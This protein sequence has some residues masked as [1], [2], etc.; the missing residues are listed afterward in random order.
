VLLDS[1]PILAVAD[2]AILAPLVDGVLVVAARDHT[3]GKQFDLAL[4][5]LAH[6]GAKVLGTVYNLADDDAGYYYYRG[7]SPERNGDAFHPK[8][9]SGQPTEPASQPAI[10]GLRRKAWHLPT[11]A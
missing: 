6:V 7:S 1:P 9:E 4:A 10:P 3:D 2:A 5:T 11:R 8:H